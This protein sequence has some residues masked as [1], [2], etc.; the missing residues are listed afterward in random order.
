M[1][2]DKRA[3]LIDSAHARDPESVRLPRYLSDDVSV[4]AQGEQFLM[5]VA[6]HRQDLHPAGDEDEHVRRRPP[7]AA[8][9]RPGPEGG[10]PAEA[11]QRNPVS[12]GEEMP[13]SLARSG[14]AH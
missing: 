2:D 7:L 13:E 6:G 5:P 9:G 14:P 4:P 1:A 8:D 10:V 12:V 11:R 3:N